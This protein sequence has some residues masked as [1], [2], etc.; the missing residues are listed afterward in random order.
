MGQAGGASGLLVLLGPSRRCQ[1]V[2]GSVASKV[3]HRLPGERVVALGRYRLGNPKVVQ[4][5]FCRL[6]LF[7][8]H[9]GVSSRGVRLL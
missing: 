4:W 5:M 1:W 9:K 2:A 8:F 6:P 3:A 7:V